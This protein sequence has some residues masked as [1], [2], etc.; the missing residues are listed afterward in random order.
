MTISIAHHNAPELR[1]PH[2]TGGDGED[3]APLRLVGAIGRERVDVS[4]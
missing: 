2:W 4:D 1:I 3:R